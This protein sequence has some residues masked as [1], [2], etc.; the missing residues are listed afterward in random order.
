MVA[1][2][3]LSLGAPLGACTAM[4][5]VAFESTPSAAAVATST[6]QSCPQTPCVIEI[7]RKDSFI[8]TFAKPGYRDAQVTVAAEMGNRGS[9]MTV[10]SFALGGVVGGIGY[11]A[12]G[13]GHDHTPNPV[14]AQLEPLRSASP[15]AGNRK[16][17]K[18][19]A[20][21]S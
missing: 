14:I 8:A 16:A 20:P 9:A 15:P 12:S 5:Q 4:N 6:G 3:G 13:H 11:A 18:K 10:A 1:G 2:L 21:P 17:R 19:A 7:P